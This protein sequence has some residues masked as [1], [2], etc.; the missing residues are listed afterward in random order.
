M[1]TEEIEEVIRKE[2]SLEDCPDELVT[3]IAQQLI[4]LVLISWSDL[5]FLMKFTDRGVC[6]KIS[7]YSCC[8]ASIV[9]IKKM[10]HLK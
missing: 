2:K 5:F 8:W 7:D 9:K 10:G 3:E 4:R 1:T 6:P